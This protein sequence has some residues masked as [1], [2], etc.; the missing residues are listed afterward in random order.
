MWSTTE[1]LSRRLGNPKPRYELAET[2]MQRGRTEEA[3]QEFHR[4][5]ALEPGRVSNT[6]FDI[7]KAYAGLAR[8]HCRQGNYQEARRWIEKLHPQGGSGPDEILLAALLDCGYEALEYRM[9]IYSKLALIREARDAAQFFIRYHGRIGWRY[10][11]ALE[12]VGIDSDAMYVQH[13]LQ[14]E[15]KKPVG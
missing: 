9:V 15:L 1:P 8:C 6:K 12:D 10:A 11:K 2:L 5:L 4:F 3:I 13:C 7:P 14:G